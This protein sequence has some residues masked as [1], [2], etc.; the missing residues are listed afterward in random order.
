MSTQFVSTGPST[1]WG[2]VSPAPR[3]LIEQ[4]WWLCAELVRR[5]PDHVIYEMHPGGGLG[6]VLMV[7]PSRDLRDGDAKITVNR[8]GMIRVD[9]HRSDNSLDQVDVR[10]SAGAL[11]EQ[12]PHALVK[13]VEAVARL[14][15]LGQAPASTSRSLAFRF[16]SATLTSLL[17]DRHSWDWRQ[18]FHDTSGDEPHVLPYLDGFPGAKAE[19]RALVGEPWDGGHPESHYWA[20]LREGKPLAIVSAEGS[21]HFPN[22]R[23]DLADAYAARGR[24][25]HRV[26]GDFILTILH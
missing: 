16:A 11:G 19:A 18:V 9:F 17:N 5:H 20:L 6:D 3:F 14:S 21:L 7:R 13:E 15:S 1:P 26:T 4:S 22:S 12:N 24:N 25:M 10:H 8:G 2:A 23:V